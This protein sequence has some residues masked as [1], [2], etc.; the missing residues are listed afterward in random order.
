MRILV[1]GAAGFVGRHL[2]PALGAAWPDAEVLTP[3][4][5]LRDPA[6]VDRGVADASPDACV[7][8]AGIAAIFDANSDPERAWATNLGGTLSLARA[9]RR[10]APHCRLVF[11]GSSDS[12]GASFR[13]GIPLDEEAP[14][15][16]LNT[17]AATKAAA[18]VALCAMAAEGL[19]VVRVR[20]F[21]HT[22]PGQSASFVVPAFARQ[23][24][25][26]AAGKQEPILRTGGL[27]P[28]RDF[29]DVRDVC[30]AYAM[31]LNRGVA[32]GTLL[33]IGSGASRRVGDVLDDLL[34]VSGVTAQ[35]ESE[36]ARKR[37][38]DIPVAAGNAGRAAEVLGWTPQ[39]P[40]ET[41]LR[42]V[43][44]DWTDRVATGRDG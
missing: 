38:N 6:A 4:F 15:A 42:D 13:R 23:L 21:N 9:I 41:T 43:L 32:P 26:I 20:P 37:P 2:L 22:G 11:A 1:T 14:L 8:L 36:A 27:E 31:C 35:A 5:D 7:H 29:L 3:R 33:N 34:R 28:R 25:R 19:N 30:R 10:H 44:A 16:P 18:D 39:I 12:Y 17:Y 40:W 24:A